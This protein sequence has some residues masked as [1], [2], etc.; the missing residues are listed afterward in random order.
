MHH[1]DK[2]SD[3]DKIVSFPLSS[4]PDHNATLVET[5]SNSELLKLTPSTTNSNQSAVTSQSMVYITNTEYNSLLYIAV[6]SSSPDKKYVA[7]VVYEVKRH[8]RKWLMRLMAAKCLNALL[9]VMPIL[10]LPTIDISNSIL[11]IHFHLNMLR[12]MLNFTLHLKMIMVT[13]N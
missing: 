13:L 11:K 10:K 12:W 5:L 6:G 3:D 9:K 1:K 4:S 7:Q 8:N 2:M